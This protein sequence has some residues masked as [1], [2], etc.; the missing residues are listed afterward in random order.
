MYKD[1][2]DEMKFGDVI[3]FSGKG[4]V[5]E[6]IKWKTNSELSHV[7]MVFESEFA[8]GEKRIVLIESTSL[9][10]LP[11]I[12][13]KELIKG[14]QQHHL[15]QRLD[16]YQGKAYYHKLNVELNDVQKR[17]MYKWL[18]NKH[19]SRTPYDS[20]QALGS[21][22]DLFDSMGLENKPDFSSLFCSEMVAK[23][24]KIAGLLREDYNPSEATPADV[25]KYDF[26]AGHRI[27]IK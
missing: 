7:G 15:S 4:V 18:F 14:V 24:F 9:V 23:V 10:N 5:S 21:A 2:R 1:L 6:L 13:T 25:V 26:L 19:A 16:L 20:A 11:D 22:L 12:R 27:Q 17:A 8:A 3:S